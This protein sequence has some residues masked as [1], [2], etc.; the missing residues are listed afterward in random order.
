MGLGKVGRV[1]GSESRPNFGWQMSATI[2][3]T[4]VGIDLKIRSHFCQ[5]SKVVMTRFPIPSLGKYG[6][7]SREIVPSVS[8][9]RVSM[10]AKINLLFNLFFNL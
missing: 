3:V 9:R 5:F 8:V 10:H 7:K 6:Q 1:L 4:E 2:R